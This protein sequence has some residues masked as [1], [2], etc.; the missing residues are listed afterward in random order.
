MK[1]LL[2]AMTMSLVTVA[3]VASLATASP[4]FTQ[5]TGSI[6]MSPAQ[7]A[8]FNAFDYGASGDRGTVNYTNFDYAA[9]GS[10]VWLP[11]VGT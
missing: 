9:P 3:L 11:V 1:R 2:A 5:A 7:F 10:G 6:S 4:T 8:A